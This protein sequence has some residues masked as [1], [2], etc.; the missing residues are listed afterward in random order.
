MSFIEWS[1]HTC[2]L[3]YRKRKKISCV[4]SFKNFAQDLGIIYKY[5]DIDIDTDIDIDR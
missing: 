4:V 3:K 1:I 5:I 2:I